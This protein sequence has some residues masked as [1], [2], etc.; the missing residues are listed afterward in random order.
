[1]LLPPETS[2]FQRLPSTEL[3]WCSRKCVFL[4]HLLCKVSH[5]SAD[6]WFK[7]TGLPLYQNK[8]EIF[9]CSALQGITL[10]NDGIAR[11]RSVPFFFTTKRRSK[12]ETLDPRTISS[13]NWLERV[14][15]DNHSSVSGDDIVYSL[16]FVIL[17]FLKVESC[18]YCEKNFSYSCCTEIFL[19]GILTFSICNTQ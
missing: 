2:H 17:H 7:V 5:V 10:P 6:C 19:R 15:G 16:I 11:K 18:D 13:P 3:K 1:M 8:S 4:N 14:A 9:T 12:K